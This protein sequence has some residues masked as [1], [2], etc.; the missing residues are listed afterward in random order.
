MN[1]KDKILEALKDPEVQRR[2]KQMRHMYGIHRLNPN[3]TQLKMYH[4]IE[5]ENTN[6]QFD[7]WEIRLTEKSYGDTSFYDFIGNVK[8]HSL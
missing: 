5:N 7:S 2:R 6:F 4:T 3:T 1:I 8:L